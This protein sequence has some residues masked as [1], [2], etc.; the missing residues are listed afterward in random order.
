MLRDNSLL[1]VL[2]ASAINLGACGSD[3]SSNSTDQDAGGAGD[4]AG[5]P[6]TGG[7]TMLTG[8]LGDLGDLKP[9]VSS[10]V[11][12]NSGESLVY[13]SSA[14]LTCPQIMISRWLGSVTA[15]AQVVEIVLHSDVKTGTF[16]VGGSGEEVNYAGGGKSSA[17]EQSATSGSLTFTKAAAMGTVEG[18]FSA[19]FKASGAHVEGVF[20]AEFCAGGQGY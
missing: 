12:S 19:D 10:Y 9:T 2:L 18:Y 4:D 3:S 14:K 20:K 8:K 17:Y 11:I 13:M 1:C 6:M 7:P 15:G 5:A 16:S